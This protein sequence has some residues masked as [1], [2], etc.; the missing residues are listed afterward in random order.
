MPYRFISIIIM[1]FHHSAINRAAG[2]SSQCGVQYQPVANNSSSRPNK[3]THSLLAACR[4]A[5]LA[6]ALWQPKSAART[7]RISAS[8]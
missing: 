1:E 3:H 8:T 7:W 2:T 5:E 4:W 6:R